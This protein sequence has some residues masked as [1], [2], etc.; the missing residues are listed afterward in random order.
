MPA[1]KRKCGAGGGA[2]RGPS[3]DCRGRPGEG[4][5]RRGDLAAAAREYEEAGQFFCALGDNAGLQASLG[6]QAV[7]LQD[8][9]D[10][11]GAMA[12]HKQKEQFC[13][14]LA[15]VQGLAISLANQGLILG[16]NLGRR[17]EGMAKAEEALRLCSRAGL[18]SLARQVQG[19]VNDIRAAGG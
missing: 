1:V 2:G 19:I 9:S 18:T 3:G 16:L 4:A 17:N 12:L 15:I 5:R 11:D 8:R 6:N 14:E 7:I 13:R 10:L